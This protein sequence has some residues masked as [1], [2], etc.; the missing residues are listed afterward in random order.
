[1]STIAADLVALKKMALLL[2][3]PPEGRVR[4]RYELYASF[5]L[6]EQLTDTSY[7]NFGYW[8]DGCESLDDASRALAD[9]LAD[10]ARFTAGDHILDVGCGYGEQDFHWLRTREPG[11]IVG[12]DI[13]PHHVRAAAERARGLEGGL[14]FQEGSAT[15]LDFAEGSFDRVVAL[16]SAFHFRTREDFFR[17]AYRV[18]RPGGVLALADIIPPTRGSGPVPAR[19]ENRIGRAVHP[20]NWYPADGYV[21]RLKGAGFH[22]VRLV[23]IG[24][25][26]YA[27]LRK[28]FA[29]KILDPHLRTRGLKNL[30][31][32]QLRREVRRESADELNV[33][34]VVVS[35]TKPGEA[36]VDGD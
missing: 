34:Y 29:R 13:T 28:Y 1:M 4:R 32:W 17:Q 6:G 9:L 35:A 27:P 19:R 25:R 12:V 3:A 11:R 24:D 14:T 10:H 15:S 2:T 21:D 5:S 30:L 7:L 36:I 26:V 20:A 18:L 8:D 23:S 16:E 31:L 22:D 33:D